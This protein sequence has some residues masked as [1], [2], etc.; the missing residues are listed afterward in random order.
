MIVTR[1]LAF[2]WARL[3]PTVRARLRLWTRHRVV[4]LRWK[5]CRYTVWRLLPD[6]VTVDYS[7][8][9]LVTREPATSGRIFDE[10][11]GMRSSVTRRGELETGRIPAIG[12][13]IVRG[14]S[15]RSDAPLFVSGSEGQLSALVMESRRLHAGIREGLYD[16]GPLAVGVRSDCLAL[17]PPKGHIALKS[18]VFFGG[19]APAA[20]FHTMV[21]RMPILAFIQSLPESTNDFPLL[22]PQE[23]LKYRQ[24]DDAI[25]TL[26]P[27]RRIVELE[28][29]IDYRVDH[30]V[31]IDEPAY[32]RPANDLYL[33]HT[34]ALRAY[35]DF[36]LERLDPTSQPA[37]GERLFIVRG[38]RSHSANEAELINLASGWGFVPWR[39]EESSFREQVATWHGARHVI[40]DTGAAWCGLLFAGPGLRGLIHT[41]SSQLL[42]WHALAQVADSRVDVLRSSEDNV[43]SVPEFRT[44][45]SRLFA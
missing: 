13:R 39:P 3:D 38:P 36:V 32:W 1:L 34:E 19:F 33:S 9:L 43:I 4:N 42:G 18:G 25:R 15:I 16:K 5:R 12:W 41:F 29:G 20:V 17:G 45:V 2:V 40:G 6:F 10:C 28:R 14:A 22:V 11:L 23:A 8:I 24:I 31:H 44:R 37:V 35:R 30:L 21:E 7:L 26:A 27:G